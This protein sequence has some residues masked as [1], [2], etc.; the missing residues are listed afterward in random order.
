MRRLS[1][2]AASAALIG[3]LLAFP[4][5]AEAGWLDKL[6][7]KTKQRTE[8]SVT[9]A[10]ADATA[11]RA[12]EE[13]DKA[14]N[15]AADAALDSGEGTEV[16]PYPAGGE[17]ATVPGAEPARVDG[18]NDFTAGTV[19]VDLLAS[20]PPGS[21]QR[22]ESVTTDKKGRRAVSEMTMAFLGEEQ[23]NGEPLI[24]MET[25]MQS[26][27]VGRDGERRPDREEVKVKIL[28]D[29]DFFSRAGGQFAALRQF[30]REVII[31]QGDEQ[32][33][34]IRNAGEMAAGV[35]AVM[36]TETA[37]S[38]RE[39]G[40]ETVSVPAGTFET[41]KITGRQR[42]ETGFAMM[43]RTIEMD[44]TVW[45]SEDVPFGVVKAESTS[46]GGGATGSSSQ[47]L[48][49]YGMTGASSA[50]TG[51]PQELELPNFGNLGRRE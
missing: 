22:S 51:T 41:R 35:G 48:L 43:R 32:P 4:A 45:V 46:V 18:A 11:E 44:S 38:F 29:R 24:W 34:L 39:A 2:A 30:G 15:A 8:E 7:D 36:N 21:W 50:I 37:Q 23:R 27:A 6:K 19:E 33:M 47:R 5:A 28:L 10:A 14:V 17:P 42:V 1:V 25:R 26:Y 40:K 12:A 9:D 20:T 16:E 49:E 31:Q 13:T 3:T